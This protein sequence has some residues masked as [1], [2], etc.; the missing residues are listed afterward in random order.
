MANTS[1]CTDAGDAGAD[2]AP[3]LSGETRVR[4]WQV[5]RRS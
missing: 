2:L 5:A 1:A 4:R 3:L